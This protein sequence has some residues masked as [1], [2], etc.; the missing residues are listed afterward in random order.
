[1]PAILGLVIKLIPTLVAV[2]ELIFNRP[3]AGEEKKEWVL[4]MAD[5]VMTGVDITL[6]G[7][8]ADTWARIRPLVGNVVDASA[9][10]AFPSKGE[11]PGQAGSMT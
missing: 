8:A 6:T 4:S 3:K 5:N 9:Q 1:M 7:G 11:V 2:A 10:I